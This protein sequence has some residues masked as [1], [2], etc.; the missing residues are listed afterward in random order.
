MYE[1]EISK[2]VRVDRIYEDAE[3]RKILDEVKDGVLKLFE[4]KRKGSDELLSR[5]KS[6]LEEKI[7]GV[8]KEI[9]V[10][11]AA[12]RREYEEEYMNKL[13]GESKLVNEWVNSDE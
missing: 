4:S 3:L 7:T 9:T 5:Y 10:K 1:S 12:K 2:R 6:E 11:N 13:V 8:M